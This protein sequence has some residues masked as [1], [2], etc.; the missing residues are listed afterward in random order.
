MRDYFIYETQW[1]SAREQRG[2]CKELMRLA[3][4]WRLEREKREA[5]DTAKG[6]ES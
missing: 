1:R 2:S 4:K 3:K 5:N 6:T